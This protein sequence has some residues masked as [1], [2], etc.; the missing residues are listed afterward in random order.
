M[1]MEREREGGEG[2][3]E[4]GR[5]REGESHSPTDMH[6]PVTFLYEACCLA[7]MYCQKEMMRIVFTRLFILTTLR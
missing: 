6:F 3:G 5:V 2:E 4:R 1:K 7:K